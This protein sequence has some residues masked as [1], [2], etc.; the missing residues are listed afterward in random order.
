MI[1]GYALTST[2]DQT[3]GFEAQ[4]R[5]FAMA[6]E[7]LVDCQAVFALSRDAW[8][9]PSRWDLLRGR[10]KLRCAL[11]MRKRSQYPMLS[12]TPRASRGHLKNASD[13]LTCRHACS[14]RRA[15]P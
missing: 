9:G 2:A 14:G 3:A 15:C 6:C 4:L 1:V 8:R 10:P 5:E 13:C 7:F 12:I 11:G